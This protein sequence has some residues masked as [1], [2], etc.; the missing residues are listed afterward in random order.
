M[1]RTAR[2]HTEQGDEL[3]VEG[4]TA[5]ALLVLIGG[6]HV[7]LQVARIGHMMG[8]RVMV[9]DDRRRVREQ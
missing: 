6:G 5:P 8:L 1:G 3:F 4:Y 7:N 9:T 2:I